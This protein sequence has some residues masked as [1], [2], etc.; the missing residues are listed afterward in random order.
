MPSVSSAFKTEII[1][2][3]F[4]QNQNYAFEVDGSKFFENMDQSDTYCDGPMLCRAM[5]TA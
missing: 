1:R 5:T 2:Y 4:K 3:S